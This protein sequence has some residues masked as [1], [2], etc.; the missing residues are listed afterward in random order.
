MGLALVVYLAIALFQLYPTWL[1]PT[2]AVPGDWRHPDSIANLWVYHWVANQVAHGRTLIHNDLYYF[3]VGDPPWLAGNASDAIPFTLVAEA[4]PWPG[5]ITFWCIFIVVANGFGGFAFCRSTGARPAGS[6]LGGAI[7]AISPYVAFELGCGRLAQAPLYGMA[8]FL[9]AW[10]RLLRKPDVRWGIL[11][12]LL[13][14]LCA[15]QYWYYGMWAAIAGAVLFAFRPRVKALLTFIP[16][17]ALTTIPLLWVFLRAWSEIPGTSDV[18]PQTVALKSALYFTFPIW[19]AFTDRPGQVLSLVL[20]TL[21]VLGTWH[22]APRLRYGL[23]VLALLFYLL[24]LGPRL[25]NAYG[26]PGSIPGPYLALYGALPVFRRFWWPYRHIAA[27]TIVLLPLAAH[28]ADRLFGW[29][30]RMRHLALAA[31][32]SVLPLEIGLRNGQVGV[33]SSWFSAPEGY[34]KL[35]SLDGAVVLELPLS[36]A[37]ARCEQVLSY[38]WVHGKTLVNGHAQWVDRVRPDAW[39]TFVASNSF[40]AAIEM[41]ELGK[42]PGHFDFAASD[43]ESL[44]E[45]GLRHIVLNSEC[46][47]DA[48]LRLAPIYQDLLDTL[49]GSPVVEQADSLRIWDTAGFTGRTSFSDLASFVPEPDEL[50]SDGSIMGKARVV[51]SLGWKPLSRDVPP[52]IPPRDEHQQALDNLPPMIRNR[53]LRNAGGMK[54]H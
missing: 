47:P 1:A 34:Q 16:V 4:L 51:L 19:G 2:H 41:L 24:S 30:G 13:F 12:G 37:L 23:L 14:G 25:V 15:F 44:R 40:L 32:I 35:A 38:Q 11:A 53:L 18:F 43:L 17:A 54:T 3:P 9:A 8:F 42:N 50:T 45:M 46:L 22:L 31:L 20:L 48:T 28:G 36:P 21:A 7:L 52:V 6:L 26:V 33:D 10:I 49:F 5:S 39:D 29:L 27:L